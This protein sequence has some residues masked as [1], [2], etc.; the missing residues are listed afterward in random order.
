MHK[1]LAGREGAG[2]AEVRGV[3][4]AVEWVEI[5]TLAQGELTTK[6]IMMF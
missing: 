4:M 2:E 6:E 1:D 5:G 3:A